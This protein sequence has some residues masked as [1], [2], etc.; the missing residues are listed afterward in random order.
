MDSIDMNMSFIEWLI[1]DNTVCYEEA[2]EFMERR[3][4]GIRKGNEPETVW[5]LE[6]PSLYTAGTSADPAELLENNK[7]PIFQSGRGGR[8]T[9]HGPGQRVVYVML[10]LKN[11]D[12]DVRKYVRD[13]EQWIMDTL[14]QFAVIG[15]RR[16]G[17]VGIWVG[18]GALGS[19]TYREDKIAAIGVRV[20]GWVTYHGIS[21]NVEPDLSHY[22]GI[23]PCGIKNYGIT[24]LWDLGLTPTMPDVDCALKASF[25]TV[26]NRRTNL[27]FS[28][29]C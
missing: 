7:F 16:Q 10:D 2:V 5:L 23:V 13:L 18:R 8:Y 12:D 17:R 9:Y 25:E 11:R 20:R 3:V 27:P 1:S 26:F 15:E 6:H 24:S 4:T 19:P 22:S 14:V 28:P 29:S 21:L